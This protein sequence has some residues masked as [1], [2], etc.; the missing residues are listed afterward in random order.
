M[1]DLPSRRSYLALREKRRRHERNTR[2]MRDRVGVTALSI[3]LE[4]KRE[5]SSKIQRRKT[6]G[7]R[8]LCGF[9]RSSSCATGKMRISLAR[10]ARNR[11]RDA[12]R[13]LSGADSQRTPRSTIGDSKLKYADNVPDKD[14]TP[15]RIFR[16]LSTRLAQPA[17]NPCIALFISF[18]FSE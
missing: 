6:L 2:K 4:L 13:Q 17:C 9:R 16:I 11:H 5:W 10:D 1:L 8:R 3:E 12:T 15:D 18:R 7:G 14:H